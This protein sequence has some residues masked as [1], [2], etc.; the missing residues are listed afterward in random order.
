MVKSWFK[1][2]WNTTV[3]GRLIFSLAAKRVPEGLIFCAFLEIVGRCW[4]KGSKCLS[5]FGCRSYFQIAGAQTSPCECILHSWSDNAESIAGIEILRLK[6][7]LLNCTST[8]AKGCL[9]SEHST[10]ILKFCVVFIHCHS[11]FVQDNKAFWEEGQETF[12]FVSLL[13]NGNSASEGENI[14]AKLM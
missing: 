3:F 13:Y 5:N 9:N 11:C 1:S 8:R 7:I 14:I 2:C 10:L 12:I 6:S 4:L